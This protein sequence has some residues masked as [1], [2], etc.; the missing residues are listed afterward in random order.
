MVKKRRCSQEFYAIEDIE[1]CEIEVDPKQ[2]IDELEHKAEK[3]K[4]EQ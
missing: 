2:P 1:Q 3:D 4:M